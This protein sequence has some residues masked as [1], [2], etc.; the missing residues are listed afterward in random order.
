MSNNINL[1]GR[2]YFI[3]KQLSD[4]NGLEDITNLG[5]ISFDNGEIKIENI[6]I[7]SV[8]RSTNIRVFYDDGTDSTSG[9]ALSNIYTFYG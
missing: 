6:P 7:S 1:Q 2:Y 4:I 3:E 9:D 8:S 5:K